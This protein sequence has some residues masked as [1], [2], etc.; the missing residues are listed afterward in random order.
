MVDH[1]HLALTSVLSLGNQLTLWC[2][3]LGVT[4]LPAGKS[5]VEILDLL[6]SLIV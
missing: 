6:T 1:L 5:D 3:A 2:Y 4:L